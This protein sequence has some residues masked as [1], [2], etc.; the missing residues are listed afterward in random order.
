ML[1]VEHFLRSISFGRNESP[2][3]E[4]LLNKSIDHAGAVNVTLTFLKVP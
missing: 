2:E 3:L 4:A 1:C